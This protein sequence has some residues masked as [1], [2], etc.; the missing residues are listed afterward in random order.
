MGRMKTQGGGAGLSILAFF[1][2]FLISGAFFP[3][4]AM[5]KVRADF[6]PDG[7]TLRLKDGRWVRLWGLDAP[8]VGHGQK[9]GSCAGEVSRRALKRQVT[10]KDLYLQ[11]EGKDR[12]GR[13]L[14]RIYLENG[15]CVNEEM[16]R[17]GMAWV[18]FHGKPDETLLR[19]MGLQEVSVR[20]RSG[21]WA[22]IP[23]NPFPVIGNRRSH[24]FHH[25]ECPL[26]QK[27]S[28]RNRIRFSSYVKAFM[29]GYAPAR[30]CIPDPVC[31]QGL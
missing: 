1:M 23:D 24:R 11:S 14:A 21:F 17:L 27:I 15:L 2:F 31:P 13:L 20:S 26:A 22:Q 3:L 7:D 28:P 16:I 6:I 5:E 10:G 18:F 12:Y 29:A 4:H 9:K 25:A 8:E 19:W 30:E